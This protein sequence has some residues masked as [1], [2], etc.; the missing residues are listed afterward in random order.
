[1]KLINHQFISDTGEV[2][3]LEHGNL[4]QIALLKNFE[5]F[6]DGLNVDFEYTEKT[7]YDCNI[8]FNCGCGGRV[9]I[10]EYEMEDNSVE[11]FIKNN[12]TATCYYCKAK[13]TLTEGE[14]DNV[15]VKLK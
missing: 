4:E 9:C 14:D 10:D 7:T 11:D 13:Y 3:P 6:K 2:V 12:K 5:A 8:T 1:M 15:I